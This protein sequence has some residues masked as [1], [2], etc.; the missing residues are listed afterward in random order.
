MAE[1]A[2]SVRMTPASRSVL[3]ALITTSVHPTPRWSPAN[4]HGRRDEPEG[5]LVLGSGEL[6]HHVLGLAIVAQPAVLDRY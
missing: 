1:G 6:G 4:G 5:S 3:S 2:A